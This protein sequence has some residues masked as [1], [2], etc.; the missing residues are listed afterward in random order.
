[1]R[2]NQNETQPKAVLTIQ[3]YKRLGWWRKYGSTLI[4]GSSLYQTK[5]RISNRSSLIV[6]IPPDWISILME[7]I[8]DFQ[9]LTKWFSL[10][11]LNGCRMSVFHFLSFWVRWSI[12]FWITESIQGIKSVVPYTLHVN[13]SKN[14]GAKTLRQK[15]NYKSHFSSRTQIENVHLAAPMSI[16]PGFTEILYATAFLMWNQTFYYWWSVHGHEI[17]SASNCPHHRIYFVRTHMA[18]LTR[19]IA[20]TF[21]VDHSTVT[22][23]K[24]RTLKALQPEDNIMNSGQSWTTKCCLDY[25]ESG[26]WLDAE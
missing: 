11:P 2:Q 20:H 18:L 13:H 7:I 19:A 21:E 17:L 22:K 5:I 25:R 16:K 3:W 26:K 9:L 24:S 1:M 23:C 10:T 6:V 12:P 15:C 4:R 8:D 14:Q